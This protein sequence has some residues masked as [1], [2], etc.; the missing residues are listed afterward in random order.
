MKKYYDVII[1]GATGFVGR[2]LIKEI[3]K[4][5]PR[6]NILCIVRNRDNSL[7]ESGKSIISKLGIATQI[8]DLNYIKSLK[9][10]PKNPKLVINLA[11]NTD[12]SDSDHRVNNLG[13]KNLYKTFGKLNSKT[14]IIHI[15]SMITVAGRL[16]CS[17][18]VDESTP[19]Y[20]TNEYTRTKLDGENILIAKCKK[21]KFRFTIIRPNTIYGKGYRKESLF[22]MVINMIKKKSPITRINWPGKSSLIHVDDVVKALIFFS[23]RS[24][25]PG[26]P[27]KYLLYSENLSIAEISQLLHKKMGIKY[28]PIKIPNY[29]WKL[30]R[31][32]RRFIPPLE[33][34][35]PANLYNIFWRLSL[36]VDD[37]TLSNT[38][39][40]A[41]IFPNPNPKKLTQ[42]I[43]DVTP[44]NS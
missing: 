23:K 5:Y 32:G 36:I 14:H 15:G 12:T 41:R 10:L 17:K 39:K 1:T 31:F 35:L 7:E 13:V 28:N 2:R 33:K 34:Y 38:Q 25:R 20:P 19:D 43:R 44:E 4:V 21:D 9:N 8:I 29:I 18:P 26:I 37:V 11:A 22:D 40:L 6:E 30:A 42:N 24:P 16:D 3:I 27:E